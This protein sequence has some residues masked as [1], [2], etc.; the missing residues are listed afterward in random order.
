MSWVAPTIT[1]GSAIT[2]YVI[3][4]YI[5]FFKVASQTFNSTATTQTMTGLLSGKSYQFSVAAINARGTGPASTSSNIVI[6]T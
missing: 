6:L 1:N 2:G 3:N 5:G 4:A